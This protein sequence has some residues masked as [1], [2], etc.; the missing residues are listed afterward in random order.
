M[1]N[2]A[3]RVLDALTAVF[4]RY[5][6]DAVFGITI[7]LIVLYFV[8][9]GHIA[10]LWRSSR[11]SHTFD[12]LKGCIESR[13]ASGAPGQNAVA[14]EHCK[15]APG[16]PET[17]VPHNSVVDE[18]IVVLRYCIGNNQIHNVETMTRDSMLRI[19]DAARSILHRVSG[20]AVVA[21][22]LGFLGTLIGLVEVGSALGARISTQRG[23]EDAL[24]TSVL[25]IS[26]A[27]ICTVATQMY[28]RKLD[29]LA[30]HL[31]S[32]LA[33]VADVVY[34]SAS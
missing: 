24:V 22:T 19:P 10:V 26:L 15:S 32:I 16:D 8:A 25:G 9:A 14:L 28:E 2:I 34:R 21:P 6:T 29:R 31:E 13:V 30:A 23:I 17:I 20:I 4:V 12:R 18:L 1:E 27:L 3:A 11:T 7:V 33:S 5:S